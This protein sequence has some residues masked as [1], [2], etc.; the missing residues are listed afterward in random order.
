MSDTPF[1]AEI[2]VG[3]RAFTATKDALLFGTGRTHVWRPGVNYAICDQRRYH[4]PPAEDC[5]CGLYAR[6]EAN[7][8]TEPYMLCGVVVAN[9]RL[10]TAKR[11]F[12]AEMAMIVALAMPSNFSGGSELAAQIA[13]FYGV[14]L[15]PFESLEAVG[16][17]YGVVPKMVSPKE[18]PK[19]DNEA[20]QRW[21]R[22]R[23]LQ[24]E[25][26][27]LAL[28]PEGP[29]LDVGA[30]PEVTR[31]R[32]I[33]LLEARQPGGVKRSDIEAK[34]WPRL[35]PSPLK[36]GDTAESRGRHMLGGMLD[37]AFA[38]LR[39]ARFIRGERYSG[40]GNV[41]VWYTTPDGN[42]IEL[43]GE[44][45]HGETE[46]RIKREYVDRVDDEQAKTE[47]KRL[48]SPSPGSVLGLGAVRKVMRYRTIFLQEVIDSG[49]RGAT[50]EDVRRKHWP[51]IPYY[52]HCAGDRLSRA[53]YFGNCELADVLAQVV[54]YLR[55]EGYMVGVLRSDGGKGYIWYA[56]DKA[57][58]LRVVGSY[59]PP[60]PE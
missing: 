16:A 6:A 21:T 28:V 46:E 43:R 57:R 56:T 25:A 41:N 10:M 11:G 24:A 5:E 30:D 55:R 4:L 54:Q 19:T 42:A 14:P 7:S 40:G 20:A 38:Y 45:K 12:R 2:A 34:Y 1:F 35:A 58:Q 29:L 9:G 31:V 37:S 48:A 32:S 39:T 22:Y 17:Q 60:S 44:Y 23:Q 8:N 49:E 26:R 59:E 33:I 50:R 27:H 15:V 13:E 51:Q 47:G 18:E 52:M 53:Q 3:F 36:R